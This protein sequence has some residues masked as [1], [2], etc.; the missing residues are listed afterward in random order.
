MSTE[1]GTTS[2]TAIV[3]QR[4]D[5][6]CVPFR[7]TLSTRESGAG[8][9][10]NLTDE[11]INPYE[12]VEEHSDDET[13]V[14]QVWPS[15]SLS[16]ETRAMTTKEKSSELDCNTYKTFTDVIA[17]R[18]RSDSQSGGGERGGG[19]EEPVR[20]LQKSKEEKNELGFR[21]PSAT[22][23]GRCQSG[24]QTSCQPM[25]QGD[26]DSSSEDLSSTDDSREVGINKLKTT[27]TVRGSVKGE[28]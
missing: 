14:K 13:L 12:C 23:G 15:S 1:S 16:S 7:N 27:V 20:K 8:M 28:A 17:K 26:L 19:Y 6:G 3:H 4:T 10:G 24:D 25:Q 18:R 11:D 9:R 21:H 5:L 2:T 22:L